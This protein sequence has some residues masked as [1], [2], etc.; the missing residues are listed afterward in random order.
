MTS[1]LIFYLFC[2]YFRFSAIFNFT[3]ICKK[4]KRKE[5]STRE[6][7]GKKAKKGGDKINTEGGNGNREKHQHIET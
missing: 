1:K 3:F 5:K 6:I 2:F 4:K 7:S